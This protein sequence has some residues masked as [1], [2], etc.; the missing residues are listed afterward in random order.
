MRLIR[1]LFLSFLFHLSSV[2]AEDVQFFPLQNHSG[3][4]NHLVFEDDI[5]KYKIKYTK[6]DAKISNGNIIIYN[7]G[8]QSHRAWFNASAEYL[9]I[10]GYTVYA[11]DRIG[12]GESSDGVSIDWREDEEG[13]LSQHYIKKKGNI[14]TWKLFTET[15]DRMVALA[16]HENEGEKINILANSFG[17]NIST[18][19]ITEYKPNHLSKAIFMA[20][21]FFSKLPLPFSIEELI[22]SKV[23]T[24]FDTVIPSVDGDNGAGMFT[25]DPFYFYAIK[26]DKY[27]I[28]QITREFYFEIQSLNTFNQRFIDD[29]QFLQ[30]LP[31]L[32]MLVQDDVMM[33]NEKTLSYITTLG[34][35]SLTKIYNEGLGGFHYLTF[36]P[37]MQTALLDIHSFIMEDQ[38]SGAF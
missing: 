29:N 2:N 3:K 9:S 11:F 4:Y 31:R 27:S 7:H 38:V 25:S 20:P 18:A 37:S 5:H 26:N 23:G 19:Y 6:W 36:T 1:F 33:D 15:L 24:Y 12:S 13:N 35:H 28:R 34:G 14:E 10:L 32:Y 17:S 16:A 21:A 8:L 22:T 30:D